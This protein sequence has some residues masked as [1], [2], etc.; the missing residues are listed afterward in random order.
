M[1][2]RHRFYRLLLK[3]TIQTSRADFASFKTADDIAQA[4]TKFLSVKG[5]RKNN[6]SIELFASILVTK[7]WSASKLPT[8]LFF[9]AF[10]TRDLLPTKTDQNHFSNAVLRVRSKTN[11]VANRPSSETTSLLAVCKRRGTRRVSPGA[12]RVIPIRQCTGGYTYQTVKW[13]GGQLKYV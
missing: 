10:R 1:I 5:S 4:V 2:W 6:F 12:L 13:V 8:T 9:S 11:R 3:Q 7:S